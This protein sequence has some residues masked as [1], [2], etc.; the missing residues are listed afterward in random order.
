MASALL[1]ASNPDNPNGKAIQIVNPWSYAVGT[2]GP[3]QPFPGNIIPASGL[4]PAALNIA[5][6]Y[7]PH[8]G[9]DGGI[10]YTKPTIQNITQVILRV[11]HRLGDKDSLTGRWYKDHVSY[12]PQNPAGASTVIGIGNANKS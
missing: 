1:S 5:Q 7:L 6:N 2:T 4:D 12:V 8:V 9:G 11:D 10:F 3:G